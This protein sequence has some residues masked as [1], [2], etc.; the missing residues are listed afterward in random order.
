MPRPKEFDEDEALQAAM[1]LFWERGYE[2]TSMSALVKRLGVARASIYATFGDKHQLYLAALDRY[3]R[4]RDPEIVRGLSTPGP[5]LPLIRTLVEGY[6]R[7]SQDPEASR[8]CLV[9]NAAVERLA[10]DEQ[11]CRRVETSWTTLEVALMS[12]LERA[13]L[14]GELN[15]EA[16]PRS[17]ASFLLVVLQGIRVV[18]RSPNRRTG[19]SLA[20]EQALDA[21][22]ASARV[23]HKQPE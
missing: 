7:E 8:G 22:A 21:V 18:G 15:P 1:E 11:A 23:G 13:R 14:Q 16:D 4:Q 2:A 17:L 12:A 5:V 20:A 3:V 6:V 9:V 19:V 10:A